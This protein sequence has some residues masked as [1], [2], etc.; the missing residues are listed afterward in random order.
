M[1]WQDK[2][3]LLSKNNY[4]ENSLIAEFFTKNHGKI[5][6][7][8][9]GSTSKKIK[10]YLLVGNKFH[11]NYN[12]KQEGRIG[13]FKVEIEKIETPIFLNNQSKLFCIIYTM[14]LIKILTVENQINKNIYNLIKNFF[15]LL[16]KE[17]WLTDYIFWE[18]QFYE[19]IGY[20]IDFKNYVKKID[21]SVENKF[22]VETS[23]RVIPNF[24]L[25]RDYDPK[26]NDE[27]L[28]GYKLVGD[29]LEK[30]ILKPNNISFPSSRNEFVNLIKQT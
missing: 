29:F 27:I 8:I 19:N 2:G 21:S 20:A 9:F 6:G 23:N 11:L 14:N 5:T 22:V 16:S 7:L 3:Y 1:I 26:N 24:I 13:Y 17:R 30:T 28:T 4:N 15:L 10:S 18:L 25:S 12:S